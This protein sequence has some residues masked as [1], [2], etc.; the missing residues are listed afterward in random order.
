MSDDESLADTSTPQTL[1]DTSI[2]DTVLDLDEALSGDVRRAERTAR[3]CIK[4]WLQ[5]DLD[6]LEAELADLVDDRG[7]PLEKPG[8]APLA[9]GRD[10]LAV[11]AE[12]RAKQEEF[13]AAMRTVRVQA[14]EPTAW[15]AFKAKWAKQIDAEKMSAAMRKE[16]VTECAIRPTI[17]LAKYDALMEAFGEASMAAIG[18]QAWAACDHT[19]VDVPKSRVF[20]AVQRQLGPSTS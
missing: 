2:V 5:G 8:D 6:E 19:G 12:Y 9:G 11:M 17:S 18:R 10:Y 20:S 13:V 16:I 3:F 1:T 14:M 15:E 7:Q 4:P